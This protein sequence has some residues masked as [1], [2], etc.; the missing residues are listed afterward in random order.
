MNKRDA[1]YIGLG[2]YVGLNI[3]L[4]LGGILFLNNEDYPLFEK[5]MP[6]IM[7]CGVFWATIGAIL[8][9]KLAHVIPEKKKSKKTKYN[10]TIDK[11]IVKLNEKLKNAI[12]A[13]V[14]ILDFFVYP[15]PEYDEDEEEDDVEEERVFLLETF[16]MRGVFMEL[17]AFITLSAYVGMYV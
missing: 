9:D 12:H 3:G 5:Y 14:T 17:I 13:D 8:G 16:G 6:I 1:E 7:L 15:G 11:M 2:S 10:P 4:F